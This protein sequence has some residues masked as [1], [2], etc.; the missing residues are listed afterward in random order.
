M[1]CS[2]R[3][4][5]KGRVVI[6]KSIRDLMDLKPGDKITFIAKGKNIKIEKEK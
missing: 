4:N 5:D 6:P 2:A 3:I 1:E